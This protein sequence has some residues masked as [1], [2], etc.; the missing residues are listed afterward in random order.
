MSGT[1][2]QLGD[3]DEVDR[4]A[5]PAD[6]RHREEQAEGDGEQ[7]DGEELQDRRPLRHVAA[8]VRVEG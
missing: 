8:D 4:V 1:N 7:A 5:V 2:A 3:E 6:D